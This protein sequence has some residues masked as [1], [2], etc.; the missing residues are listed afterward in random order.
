MML[1]ANFENPRKKGELE[2]I[3]KSLE[4]DRVVLEKKLTAVENKTSSRYA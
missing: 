3:L 4:A 1:F 2:T